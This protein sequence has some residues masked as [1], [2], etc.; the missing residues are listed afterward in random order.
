[1][2]DYDPFSVNVPLKQSP[3]SSNVSI[4]CFLDHLIINR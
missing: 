4:S 3:F 1:M 2:D